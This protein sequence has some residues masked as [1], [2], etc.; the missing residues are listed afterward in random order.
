M[1]DG[2]Y[3][4]RAL[5]LSRTIMQIVD[6]LP[7]MKGG[8]VQCQARVQIAIRDNMRDMEESHPLT[9]RAYEKA[10]TAIERQRAR[11]E[12]AEQQAAS[13]AERL[14]HLSALAYGLEA[15]KEQEGV[16]IAPGN[17][18]SYIKNV[19][20]IIDYMAL[21]QPSVEDLHDMIRVVCALHPDRGSVQIDLRFALEEKARQLE[22]NGKES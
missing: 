20:E 19:N 6:T 14:Q 16:D 17:D 8:R 5:E 10:C 13:L 18:W 3:D 21:P 22:E 7:D 11:A 9:R 4:Q 12:A 15:Y 1:T 2:Q